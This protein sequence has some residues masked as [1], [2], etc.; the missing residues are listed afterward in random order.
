MPFASIVSSQF[1]CNR[2]VDSRL[3]LACATNGGCVTGCVIG[4]DATSLSELL[5]VFLFQHIACDPSFPLQTLQMEFKA[6]NAIRL[7]SDNV[8]APS[9]KAVIGA[10]AD[11]CST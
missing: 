2:I 8:S 3:G 7:H 1:I 4:H 10:Y 5:H 6:I 11:D 9:K